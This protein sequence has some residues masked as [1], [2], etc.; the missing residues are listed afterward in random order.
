MPPEQ[1]H[2]GGGWSIQVQIRV[3][4]VHKLETAQTKHTCFLIDG[5]LGVDAGSLASSL[6]LAELKQVC[7]LLLTHQHFDHVR[8]IPTMGLATLGDQNTVDVYSIDETLDAVRDNLLNGNIY[9]DMTKPLG[10]EPPK[11]RFNP[12]RPDSDFRVL[13]YT[14][15][16]ICMPHAVPAVGYIVS[17]DAGDCFAYTGDTA[18]NLLPFL[19]SQ[20]ERHIL[21]LEVTF[22]DRLSELAGLT[23]HLTPKSLRGQLQEALAGGLNPPKMIAVHLDPE[24][25]DELEDEI[26]AVAADLR[27]DLTTGQHGILVEI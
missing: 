12:L 15:R 9:P 4:G 25:Q 21:F 6:S 18:A 8:D 11:F 20:A 23:G 22:P 19:N 1:K 3:L 14:V 10:A 5:V 13:D 16:A 24:H 26:S 17:T 27:V 7:A 2:T